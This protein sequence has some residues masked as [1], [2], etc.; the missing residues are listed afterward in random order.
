MLVFV[1]PRKCQPGERMRHDPISAVP[2]NDAREVE[3][4]RRSLTHR[5]AGKSKGGADGCESDH[6]P[7]TPKET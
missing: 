4:G 1:F 3:R 6:G 2:C 5:R 7:L